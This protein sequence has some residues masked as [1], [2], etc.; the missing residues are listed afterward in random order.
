MGTLPTHAE[1]D[2]WPK[3]RWGLEQFAAERKLLCAWTD[4]NTLADELIT[5]PVNNI[6]PALYNASGATVTEIRVEKLNKAAQTEQATAIASYEKAVLTVN[7]STLLGPKLWNQRLYMEQMST[8]ADFHRLAHRGLLFGSGGGARHLNEAEASLKIQGGMTY[9]VTF[10]QLPDLP[11]ATWQAEPYRVNDGQITT[12]RGVVY[13]P[14]T[15][16][17][18]GSRN[19]VTTY[20]SGTGGFQVTYVFRYKSN[21]GLGWNR[22]FNQQTNNYEYVFLTNGQKSLPYRTMNFGVFF[23]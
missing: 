9:S 20:A 14:E 15:L 11:T 19:I 1:M 13:P 3:E 17:Y 2:G 23:D 12:P 10:Y 7:Y 4:R 6:Y 8:H 21:N 16:L 18:V 5:D 22:F